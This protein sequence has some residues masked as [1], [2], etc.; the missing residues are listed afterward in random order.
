MKEIDL[1]RGNSAIELF[2]GDGKPSGIWYCSE[3]RAIYNQ[4]RM[5]ESCHGITHCEDCK[6][7]LENRQ[8]YY[9]TQCD[10]CERKKRMEKWEKKEFE[11]YTKSVKIKAS[12]Y[13]GPQVFFNNTYYETP[14]DAIDGCDQLPE[15]IWSA[16][17]VGLKKASI[18]D[19][20]DHILENAWKDA[21]VDDLNGIEELQE[22]IDTFNELNSGVSVYMVDYNEAIVLDEQII[23]EWRMGTRI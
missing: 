21:D 10:E 14:E 3:C 13:T 5:A 1:N 15:Y 17:D 9:R 7:E 18:D 12:E 8:P 6:K 16:K 23:A 19:L 4:Q 11:R 22:A 20:I 2:H